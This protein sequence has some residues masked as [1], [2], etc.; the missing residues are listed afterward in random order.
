MKLQSIGQALVTHGR[1][2]NPE[3]KPFSEAEIDKYLG[4]IAQAVGSILS[5]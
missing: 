1:S 2:E 3:P 5:V 4:G